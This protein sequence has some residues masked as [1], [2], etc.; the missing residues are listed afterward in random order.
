MEKDKF[1]DILENLSN[2]ILVDTGERFSIVD[3]V[4]NYHCMFKK[5]EDYEYITSQMIKG[6]VE[7]VELKT[8]LE[9]Y[10]K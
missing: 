1:K 7:I 5:K 4:N 2:F 8:Y 9:E 6:G 3:V 10:R